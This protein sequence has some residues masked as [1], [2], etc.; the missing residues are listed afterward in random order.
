MI[1]SFLA[2]AGRNDVECLI[3]LGRWGNHRLDHG[4]VLRVC[5]A[6]FFGGDVDLGHHENKLIVCFT[7][8][9]EPSVTNAAEKRIAI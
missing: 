8:D 2:G 1:P 4:D 7:S 6:G 5:S 3:D 9:D